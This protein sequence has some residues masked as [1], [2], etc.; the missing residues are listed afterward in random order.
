[1]GLP[2]ACL[3]ALCLALS[4]ARG[5]ELHR[6]EGRRAVRPGGTTE[7]GAARPQ[8][9][10]LQGEGGKGQG[11][12]SKVVT[13]PECEPSGCSRWHCPSWTVVCDPGR[14]Q[15][16]MAPSAQG[17]SHFGQSWE[18]RMGTPLSQWAG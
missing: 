5:T 7:Q 17:V 6:G 11:L 15:A 12:L 16:E 9:R 18:R 2:L 3:V 14:G 8:A 1:M 4:S 13:R 10:V